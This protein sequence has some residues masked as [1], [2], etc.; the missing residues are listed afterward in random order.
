MSRNGL[1]QTGGYFYGLIPCTRT[2][3]VYSQVSEAILQ[4]RLRTYIEEAD[5]EQV[6][7]ASCFM[8]RIGVLWACIT[9]DPRARLLDSFLSPESCSPQAMAGAQFDESNVVREEAY[10]PMLVILVEHTTSYCQSLVHEVGPVQDTAFSAEVHRDM[11]GLVCMS[12]QDST[13]A[14]RRYAG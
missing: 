12:Q 6:C 8:C 5:M 2:G 10:I 9:F 4:Q 13:K 11:L 1:A 14:R 7:P 3:G